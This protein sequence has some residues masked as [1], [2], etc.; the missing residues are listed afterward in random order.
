MDCRL[1]VAQGWNDCSDLAAAA[2]LPQLSDQLEEDIGQ[3]RDGDSRYLTSEGS[4]GIFTFEV[5][6]A[7][8]SCLWTLG[9]LLY[10]C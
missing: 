10:P 3:K 2:T 5:N 1:W 7:L 9:K 4:N 8:L 6:L